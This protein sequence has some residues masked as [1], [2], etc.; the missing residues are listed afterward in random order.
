MPK[1]RDPLAWLSTKHPLAHTLP[2][3]ER[4]EIE[5]ENGQTWGANCSALRKAWLGIK[6]ARSKG[7]EDELLHYME[8]VNE[9]QDVMGIKKTYFHELT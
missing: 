6:I 7:E 9:I 4:A 8:L 3:F 1:V 5:C 2:G